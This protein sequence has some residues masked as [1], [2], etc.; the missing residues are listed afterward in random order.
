MFHTRFQA[1][2]K[3]KEWETKRQIRLYALVV[4]LKLYTRF[5]IINK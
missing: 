4:L 5:Q 3:K 1:W 2:V